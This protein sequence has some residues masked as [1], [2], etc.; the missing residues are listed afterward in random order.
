MIDPK[1]YMNFLKDIDC[2]KT[3]VFRWDDMEVTSITDRSEYA[4][5]IQT[6]DFKSNRLTFMNPIAIEKMFSLEYID[7][8]TN[9]PDY[10]FGQ[11][12]YNQSLNFYSYLLELFTNFYIERDFSVLDKIDAQDIETYSPI[13]RHYIREKNL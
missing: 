8:I 5:M 6:M 4:K 13:A 2:L 10:T 7:L 1:I 11:P 12:I 9:F 3:G